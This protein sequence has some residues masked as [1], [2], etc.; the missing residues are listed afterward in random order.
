MKT[1]VIHPKDE[2]TDFLSRIYAGYDWTVVNTNMPKHQLKKLIIDHDRIIMLG[3]GTGNGLI[4]F[5]RA[6]IDS[7]YVYL[8]REK[9]CVCIWCDANIFV[10]KYDLKGFYT[11]MIIS[12]YYEALYCSVNTTYQEIEESNLLFSIAIKEAISKPNILEVVKE[13]YVCEGLNRT[14][15]YNQENLFTR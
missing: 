8:L 3:H 2:T 12:E 11:G 6:F 10:E 13:L 15:G 14:I 4:G 1:L 5:E 7:N 9:E